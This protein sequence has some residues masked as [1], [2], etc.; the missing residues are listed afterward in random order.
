M[1]RNLKAPSRDSKSMGLLIKAYDEALELSLRTGLRVRFLVDVEPQNAPKITPVEAVA[2][3]EPVSAK[4]ATAGPGLDRALAA[5][6]ERGRHRI[7]EILSGPEMLSADQFADLIGVSRVTVNT[8]RQARQVL[9]LEGAKRGYR[10]PEWQV[11]EDGKLPEALPALFARLGDSPW[12]V[13]R[14]LVQH[15]PE[16]DGLT[17]LEALHRG[18]TEAVLKAAQSISRGDFA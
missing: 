7:A 8:K 18:R 16:L 6:R 13:Y 14:F 9:G 2:D 4:P 17:G 10:F 11:D 3:G 1:K 12:S 5:A 15:H